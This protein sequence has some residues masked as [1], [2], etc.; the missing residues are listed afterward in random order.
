MGL[1]PGVANWVRDHASHVQHEAV[2]AAL[3]ALTEASRD[4]MLMGET[5]AAD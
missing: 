5:V 1:T 3:Q 2:G 4:L